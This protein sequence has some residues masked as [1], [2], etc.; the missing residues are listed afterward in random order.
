[1]AARRMTD[2]INL[3]PKTDF[4]KSFWGLFLKW[5]LTA[6]RY[7]VIVTEL[8][9]I[10]AFL[11]R[12]KLDKDNSDLGDEILGKQR[13]L[14]ASMDFERDFRY[15]QSK[16]TVAGVMAGSQGELGEVVDRI[17]GK[18][19]SGVKLTRLSAGAGAINISATA[20]TINV[21]GEFM[22]RIANDRAWNL[23][24]LTN[25]SSSENQAVKFDLKIGWPKDGFARL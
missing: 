20:D 1:M 11:S 18:V 17:V 14:E 24:D 15:I 9:V 16:L 3:L 7:V 12:F 22:K 5:A 4:E 25:V 21:F 8:I 6:G 2:R 23:V 19:P 13:V 10:V